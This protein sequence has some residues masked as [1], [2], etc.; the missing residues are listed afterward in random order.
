LNTQTYSP[1]TDRRL[2]DVIAFRPEGEVRVYQLLAAAQSLAAHL[3]MNKYVINLFAD[4]F[5][6]LLGFCASV[7]AGQCTLLPPNR[8]AKTVEQLA[9]DYPDSY[10]IGDPCSSYNE[11]F[12]AVSFNEPR[13]IGYRDIPRIPNDQLC[14]VALT[15]G[16]TG[17]PVPNLKYWQ[18][19]R[20]GAINN[21]GLLLRGITGQMNLLATVPAQHM[22]GFE[23][24]ILMPLFANATV[25]HLT[26]FFPQDIVDALESLPAPR[27]LISSPLHLDVLLKSGLA[28]EALERIYCATA[29]LDRRLAQALENRFNT[30]VVE[31]FG[32]SETGVLASRL[33]AN[34]DLWQLSDLF[35]IE[36]QAEG[37][38]VKGQHLPGQVVLQDVIEKTSEN[39]FRLVGRHQDM[40]NIAGKRGLLTDLNRRLLAI[41]GV[42]DGVIFVP[43]NSTERLA[44]LVVAP[45]L[46]PADVL[47]ELRLE[48]ETVFLPRPIYMVSSIPRQE[49][50]KLAHK[51]MM[52]L[53]LNIAHMKHPDKQFS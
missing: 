50:G 23:T 30:K 17:E 52:D 41:P 28:I 15:S 14:A 22:W 5:Q 2:D 33:T 42:V 24:S 20:N 49:T 4:R 48:I 34:E 47:K 35:K 1:I 27:G 11:I 6:Y 37:L 36:V 12:S 38:V 43:G 25:S 53:F 10:V 13:G 46:K 44:A 19:L 7:I 9:H 31:I 51:D 29:P 3:P 16:S 39:Q 26:P 18:T 21:A 8:L 40:I 32:S 45:G